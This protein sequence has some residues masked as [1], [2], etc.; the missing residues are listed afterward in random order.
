[1]MA[2]PASA[3][4][5]PTSRAIR[6]LAAVLPGKVRIEA[7]GSEVVTIA[8]CAVQLLWVGDGALRDVREVLGSEKD[9]PDIVAARHL[10]P[11]AREKLTEAG[12]GWVDESGAAEIAL[13]SLVVSR[14]GRPPEPV[15]LKQWTPAIL[16]VAEALLCGTSATVAA[17]EAATGLSA[18][19]CT[20]ALR[21][22]TEQGWLAAKASR[23]RN[24]ARRLTD[25]NG[26]LSA[27][28]DEAAQRARQR[29][30]GVAVG[31]QGR[32]LIKALS[33]CGERWLEAE[34]AWAATGAVAAAV[35]A[36]YLTNVSTADVYLDADTDTALEAAARVAGL[37]P[38]EGG[39]LMLRP[40]P[41]AATSR[42]AKR[43]DGLIVAPWPRVYADL[44]GAGVRGEEAAEHL[45]EVV[46]G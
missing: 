16:A 46:G 1:M 29:T 20:K 30:V 4:S 25:A 41:T 23:G 22:L 5:G 18:G 45:R 3:S 34:L 2:T 10:S 8:D 39:R 33:A 32:D 44:L 28:A 36:P 14:S 7:S 6:A 27:Y 11:A 35:I 40:F 17:T 38:I 13:P 21:F 15:R 37:R 26:L 43:A 12:V 9:Q 42:L 24:S 31:I 19:S